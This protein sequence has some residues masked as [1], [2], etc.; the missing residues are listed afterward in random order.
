MDGGNDRRRVGAGFEEAP[1]G[2]Q[3]RRYL[4]QSTALGT[5]YFSPSCYTIGFTRIHGLSASEKARVTLDYTKFNRPI[6][7]RS[8]NK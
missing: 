5:D 2:E 8:V 3:R 1:G 6:H 4:V 7:V